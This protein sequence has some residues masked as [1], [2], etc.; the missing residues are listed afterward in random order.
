V[1]DS[2]AWVVGRGGM[3]GSHVEQELSR[4]GR[5]VWQP[6]QPIPWQDPE[7]AA[8]IIKDEA[9][10]FRRALGGNSWQVYWCAGAGVTAT[11]QHLLDSEMA[12]FDTLLGC[13]GDLNPPT[14]SVFVASSAGGVYAGSVGPPF[15][16]SSA[17]TPLAPYGRCKLAMEE[18]A[19]RWA[20]FSGVSVF[21]GRMSNV[22]GP[23]QDLGKPQGLISHLLR[24]HVRRVPLR[25]YVPLDTVRDYLYVSDAARLIVDG[26][27]RLSEER[28]GARVTKVV[29]SHHA[30]ALAA[31]IGEMGRVLRRRPQIIM[32]ASPV[33]RFQA[34]D[35]RLQSRIWPELERHPVT[36]FPVGIHATVEDIEAKL[37]TGTLTERAPRPAA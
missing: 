17:P 8:R 29:A 13:L 6:R 23:G 37:R 19:N 25:V 12:M 3:I 10:E 35:L 36:P 18:V 24:A 30:V 15:D 21:V 11:A 32:A 31:V 28:S 7:K 26:M 34:R 33:A 14:G 2:L 9:G 4:R 16:E 1:S 5:A 27:D 22:Y 20:D